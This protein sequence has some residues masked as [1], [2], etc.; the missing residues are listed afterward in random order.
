M[1]PLGFYIHIPFCVK[2]CD[3]CD[4][5][6]YAD[7]Y[8]FV[9]QYLDALGREIEFY[10][11]KGMLRHYTPETLYI[12]GGTPSLV[13]EGILKVLTTY[14]TALQWDA[15]LEKSIEVNPKAVT[16]E[17]LR[18]LQK[19]G[20]NRISIGIQSFNNEELHT[21]GRIHSRDDALECVRQAREAGFRNISIDL[22]F[23]IPASALSSWERSLQQAI[24]LEPEHVAMYNLTIEA[25][26]PFERFQQ[27]GRLELPDD[28]L[29]LAM[30]E[31]GIQQLSEAGY[32]Q[33]EISNFARPGFRCAHNQMYWRNDEYLGFGAAAHSYIQDRRYWNASE[34]IAYIVKSVETVEGDVL[35]PATVVGEETLNTPARMGE[36][37]MMNLRMLDGI[38]LDAFEARFGV[39]LESVYAETLPSLLE[40]ELLEI[41]EHHLRLTQRGLY[42]SNSVFQEFLSP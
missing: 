4:F 15:L 27:Q 21:L 13:T 40:N 17:Q 24:E 37:I 42:V 30:Y 31:H 5:A 14:R 33:Y 28:D 12:G 38:D 7:K 36:T 34:V 22:M 8:Q 2:K 39:R 41:T 25:G 1:P 10:S 20:F 9:H 6:S 19:A 23:G 29:Q 35:Y 11:K 3:Y 32:E 26:T 18:A 16:P